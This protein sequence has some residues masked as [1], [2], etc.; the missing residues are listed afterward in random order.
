[1]GIIQAKMMILFCLFS[2]NGL[3][4]DVSGNA[5]W[6]CIGFNMRG[7]TVSSGGEL[8]RNGLWSFYGCVCE[9]ARGFAFKSRKGI[10]CSIS[11]ALTSYDSYH[12]PSDTSPYSY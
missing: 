5:S 10:G 11:F 3:G 2:W 8:R 1:M 6:G 7:I 9:C 4:I 12:D